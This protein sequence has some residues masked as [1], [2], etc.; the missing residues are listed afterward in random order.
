MSNK[1][2][3]MTIEK[4]AVMSTLLKMQKKRVLKFSSPRQ[5]KPI[6]KAQ[7]TTPVWINNIRSL[8]LRRNKN[9]AVKIM[10]ILYVI[11]RFV[12]KSAT[13]AANVATASVASHFSY[14]AISPWIS[15]TLT[16]NK[17][18]KKKLLVEML[19]SHQLFLQTVEIND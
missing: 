2:T 8:E 13:D 4:N 11:T 5:I 6:I 12:N 14:C 15:I 7:S 1:P 17:A 3:K 18:I 16:T 19:L 10:A 9:R